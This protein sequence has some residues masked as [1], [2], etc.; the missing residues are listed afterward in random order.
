MYKVENTR[1]KEQIAHV[2][3][4]EYTGTKSHSPTHAFDSLN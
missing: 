4:Y 3:N 2:G 1:E